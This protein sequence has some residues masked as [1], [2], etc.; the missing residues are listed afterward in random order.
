MTREII[1]EPEQNDR[2]TEW[3]PGLIFLMENIDEALIL[4]NKELKIITFSETFKSIYYKLTGKEVKSG[5]HI[6]DYSSAENQPI[7][8]DVYARV[9]KGETIKRDLEIEV[10]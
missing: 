5:D 2:I 3:E 4:I 6:L 9:F 8:T 1:T 7:L 10:S